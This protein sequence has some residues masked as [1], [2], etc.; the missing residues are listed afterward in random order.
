MALLE[1]YF[2]TI[3]TGWGRGGGF[4]MHKRCVYVDETGP[5][6]QWKQM[7]HLNNYTQH[8]RIA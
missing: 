4:R 2:G 7:V 8:V 5:V 6:C 1:Q 3:E